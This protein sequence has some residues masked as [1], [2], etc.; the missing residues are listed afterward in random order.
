MKK[1]KVDNEIKNKSTIFAAF[2]K[3]GFNEKEL[4]E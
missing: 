4:T 2:F 3:D 1:H